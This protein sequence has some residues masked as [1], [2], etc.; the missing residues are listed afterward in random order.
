MPDPFDPAFASAIGREISQKAA[1]VKNDPWCLGY[2]VQNE[3]S[4]GGGTNDKSHYGLAY[5]ALALGPDSPSKQAFIAQLKA[6]YASVDQLNAAWGASFSGWDDLAAPYNSPAPLT[7]DAQRHDFAAFLTNYAEKYFS[8]V[9]SAIR[10]NDPNHMY[11]GCR[12]AAFTPEEVGA[13]A[14]YVDVI[15]FNIYHWNKSSY[16]F[17]ETLGKPI[18]IGE[19]HFGA[20]DRGMF[21]GGL[22]P[23]VDQT[24]RGTHYAQYVTTVLS[25]PAFVGC[26]WFEFVDEPTTGRAGDGENYNIGFVSTTDTPYPEIIAAARAV[27]ANV[28]AIHNAANPIA[29]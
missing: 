3:L 13:A 16:A 8:V 5:G 24:D 6:K 7:N 15:S 25:E 26:H 22:V 14:K 20:L 10:S 28:Y 18:V 2:F 17:A 27:H 1:M 4:W 19:F 21:S 12:F 11:L 9:S 23:V 29:H